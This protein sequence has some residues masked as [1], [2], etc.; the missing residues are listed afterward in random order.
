MKLIS[1][2]LA[3]CLTEVDYKAEPLKLTDEIHKVLANAITLLTDSLRL[4]HWKMDYANAL[5]RKFDRPDVLARIALEAIR[6]R[7]RSV[8]GSNR[9]PAPKHAYIVSQLK[10]PEE[11]EFLRKVYGRQFI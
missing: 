9:K 7:R 2:S 1:D 6:S 10:S 3:S 8:T 5:R 11:V 4:Y